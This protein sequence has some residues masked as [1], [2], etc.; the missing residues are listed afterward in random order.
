MNFNQLK[1]LIEL[2]RHK[3]FSA[4]AAAVNISQ[5]A[6]SI[7]IQKLE[8][9]YEFTLIDRT[10]HPLALTTEGEL[11]YEKALEIVQLA[12]DLEQ[13]GLN[14]EGQLEGKLRVGIIPTL[15]PYLV[16]LFMNELTRTYPSIKVDILELKT[17]DILSRLKYNELD[18]G[19]IS[20]PVKTTNIGFVPLFYEQF[21][22][23]VS[24]DHLLFEKDSVILDGINE[25]ELHYLHEGNCFQNQ[26]NSV[27]RIPDYS[28]SDAPFRYLS[29]SIES[30]KRIVENQG[31]LTFIPEL[32]TSNIPAE[33]ETMIKEIE[34]PT[35]M[36]EISA[37][38]LKTTGYKKMAQVFVEVLLQNIPARMK[39]KPS[40]PPLATN[41]RS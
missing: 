32:A 33:Y 19:I 18:L 26:V 36:R 15:S 13:L 17:E 34:S 35:P 8:E 28:E 16:P 5:P 11:F 14:F 30:L 31:G 39:Q 23:Y 3:S 12:E 9:E 25:T 41:I 27:C 38:Y 24:K 20:T 7:Q 37:C 4:A 10:K 22:L 21:Y 1:Y 2:R 29:N 6:L 40:Q